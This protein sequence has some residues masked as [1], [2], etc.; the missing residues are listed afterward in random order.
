LEEKALKIGTLSVTGTVGS[1]TE[2][3]STDIL[4]QAVNQLRIKKARIDCDTK[5][6][7]VDDGDRV[8]NLKPGMDCSL[9]VEV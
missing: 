2:T 6:Q 1:A 7:S 8:K 9:E 4:M 3:T 5:S